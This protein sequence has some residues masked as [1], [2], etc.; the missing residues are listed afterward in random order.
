MQFIDGRPLSAVIRQLRDAGAT[1]AGATAVTAVTAPVAGEATPALGESHRSREFFRRVAELGAQA[2]EALEY[3]HQMGVVHRDVKPAN[4]MLDGA[5]RLWVTDFGL[6]Q[7]QSDVKLTRT[8]DVVG[9]LRYMSPEQAAVGGGAALD[10]RTDVYSL[11]ATL[12][13]LL[14][15]TPAVGSEDGKEILRRIAFEEPASPRRLNRAVPK[16]L[17]TIVLKAMRQEL[18]ARYATARVLADDLKRWLEDKPIHAR[19]PSWRQMAAKWMRRHRPVIWAAAVC[20]LTTLAVLAGIAGWLARD[21]SARRDEAERIAREALRE[22]AGLQQEEKWTEALGAARRADAVLAGVESS[23]QLRDQVRNLCADLRM[24]GRLEEARLRLAANR[25]GYADWE[26]EQSAFVAAFQEYGLDVD[27]LDPGRAGEWIQSRS[28]RAQ[29]VA[30]LDEWMET[31]RRTGAAGWKHLAAVARAAEPD[32]WRVQLR[33]ALAQPDES[34]RRRALEELA[35]RAPVHELSPLSLV[36][37]GRAL[38]SVGSF[39]RSVPLLWEAC[40]RYPGDFWINEELAINLDHA[41]PPL[42]EEAVRFHT[43][44]VSLRPQ[45]PGAHLWLG[46]ALLRK[47]S[48]DEAMVELHE[49][50]RLQRDFPEAR[51]FLRHAERLARIKPRLPALLNGE[52]QPANFDE[53]LGLAWTLSKRRMYKAAAHWCDEALTSQPG[54]AEDGDRYFAACVAALAACGHGEDVRS[55]GDAERAQLHR[56]ALDW[57]RA[58]LEAYRKLQ[59]RLPCK[60][61]AVTQHLICWLSDADLIGVRDPVALARLPEA[62]QAAWRAFWADVDEALAK[63]RGEAGPKEKGPETPKPPE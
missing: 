16:E 21:R 14:T 48:L 26:G 56:Q 19:R 57:L 3:A 36:L 61:L 2:A 35:S 7:V 54:L 62:E 20:L 24:A 37:L 34:A 17:E 10:H 44:A 32:E 50:V 31:R 11:G 60:N 23:P 4:L 45:S 30:A 25:D 55:L 5:G 15:L 33:D 59:E 63:S 52:A 42:R 8:G 51:F 18:A 12:Y 47:G 53:R 1:S 49:A 27:G 9:T 46:A 40:R 29:L 22:A 28:I 58:D 6:A 13:E 38:G 43:A 41:P 39:D